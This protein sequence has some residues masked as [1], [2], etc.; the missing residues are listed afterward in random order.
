MAETGTERSP[1]R[2]LVIA[3]PNAGRRKI[4]KDW[5]TISALLDGAG[6]EHKVVFTEHPH[7]ADTLGEDYI[8]NGYRRIIVVGGDGTMNEAVNG[9]FRQKACATTDVTLGMIMVGTGNDWGRMYNIP[10]KYEDSIRAIVRQQT[11]IQDAAVVTYFDGESDKTRYFAN[12]AG[13]GYD[14]MVAQMTNRMKDKG[15]G[16]PLA[17]L[18][19]LFK[20][21]FRYR[22]TWMDISVDGKQVYKGKVFSMSVGICRFNGGGMMQLPNA[23]PD[24]GVLDMTI[25]KVVTKMDVIRNIK[26]LF[27]GS[28]LHLPFVAT[29]TGKEIE[30]STDP[31]H[32][33]LLETDGESLG[34][35][36]FR[37]GIM[38]KAIKI[39]AGEDWE[40]VNEQK[41][42]T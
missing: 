24:D 3:N 13:T 8:T 29:H 22:H 11:F 36:P 16:G 27:D 37:F 5:P 28:F 9:I 39:I 26:K 41:K 38:P 25:L 40:S 14:A 32:K 31:P 4:R 35:S 17:Y 15:G 21:L 10:E 1:E 12:M 33:A 34:N 20:G 23:V 7:H 30:I 18:I 42:K 19:N 2:W 6:L